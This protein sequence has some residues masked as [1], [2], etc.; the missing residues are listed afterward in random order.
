M[1]HSA[2]CNWALCRFTTNR[3][4]LLCLQTRSVSRQVRK[5]HPSHLGPSERG[6]AP[7]THDPAEGVVW[8]AA[9]GPTTAHLGRPLGDRRRTART[10]FWPPPGPAPGHTT[11]SWNNYRTRIYNYIGHSQLEL[12]IDTT[13]AGRRRVSWVLAYIYILFTYNSHKL[14]PYTGWQIGSQAYLGPIH[15]DSGLH[16]RLSYI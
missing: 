13:M 12:H 10:T 5:K 3:V 14:M 2:E 15:F 8:S 9:T 6:R 4:W 16:G 7:E 11:G 1:T